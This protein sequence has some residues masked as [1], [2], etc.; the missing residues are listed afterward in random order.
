M[1]NNSGQQ[2]YLRRQETPLL[3]EG[4]IGLGEQ[5]TDGNPFVIRFN[6]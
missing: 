1:R 4:A 5:V 3:G 6:C 2:V